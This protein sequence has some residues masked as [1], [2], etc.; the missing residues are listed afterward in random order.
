MKILNKKLKIL[1]FLRKMQSFHTNPLPKL[2]LKHCPQ[3][4]ESNE[5]LSKT[6]KNKRLQLR[7]NIPDMLQNILIMTKI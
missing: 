4:S 2:K 7:K 6:Y 1:K 3:Y 5:Q